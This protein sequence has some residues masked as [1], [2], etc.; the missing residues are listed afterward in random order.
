MAIIKEQMR[1]RVAIMLYALEH[2][3]DMVAPLVD[4][5]SPKARENREPSEQQPKAIARP[6]AKEHPLASIAI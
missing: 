1:D 2:F 6:I 3:D 5:Q 4:R